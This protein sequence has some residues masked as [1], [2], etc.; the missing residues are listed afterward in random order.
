M[1]SSDQAGFIWHEGRVELGGGHG[2]RVWRSS[3]IDLRGKSQPSSD[4]IAGRG[5]PCFVN[6]GNGSLFAIAGFAGGRRTLT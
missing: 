5:G 4:K 2:A 3:E 1:N 6:G